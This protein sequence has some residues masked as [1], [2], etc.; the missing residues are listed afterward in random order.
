MK[1][2]PPNYVIVIPSLTLG[3]AE[4]QAVQYARALFRKGMARPILVGLGR[5]GL[6]TTRLD[7]LDIA[8]TNFNARPFFGANRFKKA[9]TVLR[10]ALFLRSLQPDTIIG[11]TYWPNLLCGL[12]WRMS[13]AK[14]FFWNQRSVDSTIAMTTWEQLAMQLGPDYLSNGLAGMNFI[15]ERHKLPKGSVALIP[16]AVNLPVL[17][18]KKEESLNGVNMVNLLM[19]A[20]F[21]PEKDHATLLRALRLYLDRADAL[22]VHLHLVGG[23]P[24][25]SPNLINAKAMTF[26][27]RLDNHV[28]FHGKV[29]DMTPILTGVHIGILSTRSEGVSNAILEYMAYGLPVLATDIIANREALGPAQAEWLFP[30]EDSERLADLL[31]AIIAHPDRVAIGKANR[32]YVERRH[33]LAIFEQ[34]LHEALST[35]QY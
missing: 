18:H 22:P 35:E 25:H 1:K 7:D 30:V 11:F 6:L 24:G 16:N 5:D 15:E 8:Y 27:L 17:Q 28:T 14:R 4:H 31:A 23:A 19:T 9:L 12:A 32:N 29:S 3:G 26:D 33:A 21:Y 34:C 13:G 10:F 20:N 2:D